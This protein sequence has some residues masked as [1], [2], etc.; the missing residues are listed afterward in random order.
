MKGSLNA[1]LASYL[2][3]QRLPQCSS[4][5]AR[6]LVAKGESGMAMGVAFIVVLA[7]IIATAA[8][9][10][11]A[12]DGLLG[13]RFQGDAK[14]ARLVAE[15]GTS[16]IISEWNKPRNRGLYQGVAMAN[17]T[18]GEPSLVNACTGDPPDFKDNT[19]APEAT[20]LAFAN[21]Q[22]VSVDGDTTRKFRLNRVTISSPDGQ[23]VFQTSPS[24]TSVK[25]GPPLGNAVFGLVRLEV[26]GRIY[27]GAS[28]TPVATSVVTREFEVVRKCCNKSFGLGLVNETELG[29]DSRKCEIPASND[30]SIADLA[31][32][33]GLSGLTGSGLT[34]D[35]TK[36]LNVTLKDGT[37]LPS[38]TCIPPPDKLT[39]S[40]GNTKGFLATKDGDIPYV[41]APISFPPPPSLPSG[42]VGVLDIKGSLTISSNSKANTEDVN[43]ACD[44]REDNGD[45]TLAYHCNLAGIKLSGGSTLAVDTTDY[46]VYLYLQANESNI[47]VGGGGLI[48]H[49]NTAAGATAD[50]LQIRGINSP[51]TPAAST[52]QDFSFAGNSI[53]GDYT[54]WAPYATTKFTGTSDAAGLVWTNNA[55]ITGTTAITVPITKGDITKKCSEVPTSLPCLILDDSKTTKGG[56]PTF[57]WVARAIRFTRMF[58]E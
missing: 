38:I 19:Q 27:R 49:V 12:F 26:E 40:G 46:P 8:L 50:R 5:Q 34:N 55:T 58:Q 29:I 9:T 2:L 15:S 18:V 4:A 39:C 32:I 28:A 21:G 10:T 45:G 24:I 56:S 51:F 54:I 14:D 11:R 52:T 22:E 25:D 35:G 6:R 16:F 7:I 3:T 1:K 57:D 47:S 44:L 37:I 53:S 48:N 43:K 23:K 17:W 13:S 36:A 31:I 41:T 42:I 33:T 30:F 20:A